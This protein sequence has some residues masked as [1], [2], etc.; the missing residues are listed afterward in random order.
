MVREMVAVRVLGE[1]VAVVLVTVQAQ[2]RGT[3]QNPVET[4]SRLKNQTRWRSS[5]RLSKNRLLDRAR[6][7]NA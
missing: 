7:L 4:V 2:E 6:H 1:A 3:V 5:N